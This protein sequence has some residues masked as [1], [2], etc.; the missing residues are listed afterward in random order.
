[1]VVLLLAVLQV[2]PAAKGE[3]WPFAILRSYGSYTA[4][5]RF[6]DRVFTAQDRHPGLFG[7][8]WFGSESE[9]IFS[10]PEATAEV[11]KR[12]V[13]P[14]RELC[15]KR[16]IAFSYQQGVT[17][18]HAPDN[19]EHPGIP[20][21]CWAVDRKGR[22]RRGLFCCTSPFAR[23]RTRE[24]V[25]AIL[26]VLEPDSYWPDDDL[27]ITK[28][29]W[30]KPS[31]CFCDRC[32]GLFN[33]RQGTKFD[34]SGLVAALDDDSNAALRRDWCAFNGRN[35]GDFARAFREAVDAVSPKTR[36][37]IQAAFTVTAL[38]GDASRQVIKA[39]AGK[40]GRVGIRPGYGHYADA[41][42]RELLEKMVHVARES[43]RSMRLPETA[44]IC[45]ECENWP[46]VGAHKNAHGQMAECAFALASGCDSIAFYWGA[47]RNGEDAA[48]YDFWLEAVAAWRPFHLAVRD[49]FAGTHLGGV[50]AWVGENRYACD[51]WLRTLE[52]ELVH[53]SENALPITVP[54]GEPDAFLAD[55]R[56]VRTLGE[57][58]LGRLFSKPVLIS[59]KTLA[60]LSEKFP[61]LKFPKKV[62]LP[63]CPGGRAADSRPSGLERFKS[64]QTSERIVSMVYPVSDDVVRLSEMT[65]DP[66]ACGTCVIPT[67]F[68]GHVVLAQDVQCKRVHTNWPGCRRHAILDALDLAVP[69][70][71]PARIMTD[72]YAL[73]VA[74]R[75]DVSGRTAGVFLMNLGTGETPT[76]ELAIR[77]GAAKNW[78]VVLPRTSAVA[79]ETVR[80]SAS[81]AVVRVPSLPAFGVALVTCC[82]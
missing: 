46:H 5:K 55:D 15:K 53:L 34:R 20:D 63:N 42:P 56:T 38:E 49:A 71:M 33:A 7:E 75:K 52:A 37:G 29:D 51:D 21:D 54:E 16:G 76:L 59:P 69:G 64:G 27:R 35:L 62:D 80:A 6:T 77:R 12:T 14:A 45:Y 70:G 10:T 25:K 36:L 65:A 2:L 23:D 30:E 26:S 47:D 61:S 1:M 66:K 82:H 68:G 22:I 31:I 78:R 17:L 73:A 67:E 32:L 74:V 48:S 50:A 41:R 44:Q 11:L 13:L 3:E 28:L 40:G 79:A 39:L 18:G 9:E 81:E 58:D 19:Q 43:E 57:G 4:N 72:G 60:A 24:G 8:I